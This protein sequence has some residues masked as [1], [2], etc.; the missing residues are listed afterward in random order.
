MKRGVYEWVSKQVLYGPAQGLVVLTLTDLPGFPPLI[1]CLWL[2]AYI[3]LAWTSATTSRWC[4][5]WE[6]VLCSFVRWGV[7][8]RNQMCEK[9]WKYENIKVWFTKIAFF[10]NLDRCSRNQKYSKRLHGFLLLWFLIRNRL[11]KRRFILLLDV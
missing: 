8:R 5:M 1:E 4:I 3:A 10:F 2:R 6:V 7:V 11:W 9:V